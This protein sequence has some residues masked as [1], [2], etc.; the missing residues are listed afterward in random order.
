MTYWLFALGDIQPPKMLST[1][2]LVHWSPGSVTGEESFEADWRS[3]VETNK[4][5]LWLAVSSYPKNM[6]HWW[7]QVW[8]K[9]VESIYVWNYQTTIF[10]GTPLQSTCA[11]MDTAI[12]TGSLDSSLQFVLFKQMVLWGFAH[13]GAPPA[14]SLEL[15]S[16]SSYLL[17]FIYLD[18]S[19]SPFLPWP[20][21]TYLSIQP[22][23]P[24]H[25]FGY[26]SHGKITS[27]TWGVQRCM[28]WHLRSQVGVGGQKVDGKM[29]IPLIPTWLNLKIPGKKNT[30]I[31]GIRLCFMKNWEVLNTI[32]WSNF[33]N[34]QTG[35]FRR[36]LLA[37][38]DQK[39]HRPTD[40]LP[41]EAMTKGDSK[42]KH[43]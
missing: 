25:A 30:C 23:R 8:L 21:A 37:A 31:A 9:D 43:S 33:P 42:K 17:C 3:Y 26:G 20:Q 10:L 22:G 27:F 24:A 38:R 6:S 40:S 36:L 35:Q 7:S 15:V 18:L 1:I 29:W 11:A 4:T 39:R 5:T 16:E 2:R 19:F 32:S 14:R 12:F 41:G 28:L 34:W 13:I